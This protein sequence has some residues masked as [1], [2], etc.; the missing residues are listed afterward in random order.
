MW[1]VSPLTALAVAVHGYHP[2]AEDG[3][4]YLAGIKRILNPELYP[5]WSGFV[6]A[7]L[8]FSLFAPFVATL[9]RVSHL[10]LMTMMLALYVLSIWLTLF[11]GWEIA[12]RCTASQQGRAGAVVLLAL[13]LT[14]P[15]AGTSLMLIDPY[16]TARSISTPLGLLAL[17]KALDAIDGLKKGTDSARMSAL[18]F[19]SYLLL[20]RACHP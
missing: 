2:F 18:L 20:A 1:L 5:A 8:R 16:V 9:V 6:T 17:A 4:V 15:I 19:A 11:A 13:A 7:H 3:G 12:S 14:M 10:G